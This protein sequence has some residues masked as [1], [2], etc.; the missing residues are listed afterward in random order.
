MSEGRAA[1][2]V[3]AEKQIESNRVKE[4]GTDRVRQS[5]GQRDRQ[6]QTA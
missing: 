3:K 4:K 5:L 2:R 6:S 1:Y